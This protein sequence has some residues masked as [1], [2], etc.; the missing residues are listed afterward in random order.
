MILNH[1]IVNYFKILKIILI[2]FDFIK[3]IYLNFNHL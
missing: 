1:L 3:F 2:Y